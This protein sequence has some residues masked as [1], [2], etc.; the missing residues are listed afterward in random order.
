MNFVFPQEFCQHPS[1]SLLV[2]LSTEIDCAAYDN[3][4]REMPSALVSRTLPLS[5]KSLCNQWFNIFRVFSIIGRKLEGHLILS[6]LIILIN[7]RNF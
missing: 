4:N 2:C 3:N 1:I 5:D 7:T 6:S